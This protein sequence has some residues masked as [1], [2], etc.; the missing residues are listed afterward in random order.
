[1]SAA[2]T[3]LYPVIISVSSVGWMKY[4]QF[5]ISGGAN[6]R[7]FYQIDFFRF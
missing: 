2:R 3:A 5:Y 7:Y 1:M 4:K 6:M